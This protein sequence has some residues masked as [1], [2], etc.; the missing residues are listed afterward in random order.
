MKDIEYRIIANMLVDDESIDKV[1]DV[2]D[3]FHEE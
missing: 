3:T 2:V 1:Q